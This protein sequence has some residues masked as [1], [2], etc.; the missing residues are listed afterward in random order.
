MRSV[1]TI[2]S[3]SEIVSEKPIRRPPSRRLGW[4]GWLPLF[5][6]STSAI[7]LQQWYAPWEFMWLLAGGIFAGCKWQSWWTVRQT[8]SQ[9]R[10]GRNLAYLFL[11]PGMNPVEFLSDAIHPPRP[12]A[13]EWFSAAAKTAGGACILW[14][15]VRI[16]PIDHLLFAGWVGMLGLIFVLHFGAFHLLSLAWRRAG[17]AAEPIMRQPLKS[18]SLGE[19]WGRRWNLGF[20][21]L[22]H[23]W[24]FRPVE[25]ILGAPAATMAAFLVSGLI[26][27]LVISFPARGGY[28]LP[29]GYF[30]LQGAGVLAER[31]TFGRRIGLG[32]G[33]V[34]WCWMALFTAGPVFWLFHPPFVTRVIL[35]FLHAIGAR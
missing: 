2:E 26:H 7:T 33:I 21:Q 17:I 16:V 13:K 34:G 9:R 19:L 5:V 11:W 10:W 15:G 4:V 32:K 35:P 30:L 8:E 6:L 3:M 28:G 22:S 12:A 23:A 29:T 24:V 1:S 18:H 27:D 14:L 25:G 31:S 20:R